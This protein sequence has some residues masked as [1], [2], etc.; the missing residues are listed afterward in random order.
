MA[1]Q[2]DTQIQAEYTR[3]QDG[4]RRAGSA[5]RRPGADAAA[6][7]DLL[8]EADA[9]AD[10][11]ETVPQLRAAYQRGREMRTAVY[12]AGAAGLNLLAL[13]GLTFAGIVFWG[14]LVLILAAIVAGAAALVF[15]D[16]KAAGEQLHPVLGGAALA[17]SAAALDLGVTHVLTWVWT[18]LVLAVAV[19]GEAWWAF[20]GDQS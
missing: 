4:V 14:W 6:V 2:S 19:I 11:A 15:A 12:F 8:R 16:V 9:L 18:V 17:L 3:L 1:G 13:A 20:E 5:Y 7:E 10:Y